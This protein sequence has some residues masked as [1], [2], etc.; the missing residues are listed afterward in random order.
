MRSA[1]SAGGGLT[2]G[3]VI[4]QGINPTLTVGA[5]G[6][7]TTYGGIISGTG[8][9]LVKTGT[10]TLTFTFINTFT[11][12]VAI[13]NGALSV[14]TVT[15]AGTSG[16]LGAGTTVTLGG[17]GTTGRL[18]FTGTA[19][20]ST[21]RAIILSAGGG[22]VEVS[23]PTGALTLSGPV[24]GSGGLAKTGPGTLVLSGSNNYGGPTVVAAGKLQASGGNAIG[25]GSAL[26]VA[27]VAGAV[28]ELQSGNETAGSLGGGGANGGLVALNN[29]TLTVGGDHTPTAFAGTITG[30]GGL[31]KN[32]SG[33]MT[34]SGVN[35]YTGTT[36]VNEGILRLAGG[37]A[38]SDAVGSDRR[39]RRR[40]RSEW[41]E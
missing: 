5:N 18:L 28:I 36:T 8:G 6:S 3:D 16:L 29:N 15:N 11:G 7:S 38:I 37:A 27:N 9:S 2:G 20:D 21:N 31:T 17:I 4:L 1:D 22:A 30:S 41:H 10:G 24:S 26:S 23:E 39:S 14:S 35:T 40:V 19:G 12:N 25:D 32:G 33:T 13:G 34:L